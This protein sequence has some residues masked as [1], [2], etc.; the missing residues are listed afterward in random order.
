MRGELLHPLVSSV[1]YVACSRD[2]GDPTVIL[3]QRAADGAASWAAVSHPCA[4]AALLFPGDLLHGVCPQPPPPLTATRQGA[5]PDAPPQR[6]TLMINFWHKPVH[7]ACRRSTL[8]ACGP[9]PRATR[10][11]TWPRTLALPEGM[12]AAVDAID[13]AMSSWDEALQPVPRVDSNPWQAIAPCVGTS[14]QGAGGLDPW[15]GRLELPVTRNSRFFVRSLTEFLDE[16]I[17]SLD[18]ST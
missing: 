6:V 3:N 4:G 7:L 2:G 12:A 5:S 15:A 9:V 16:H 17:D 1:T 14:A 11:C 13:D 18:A 10:A 8:D